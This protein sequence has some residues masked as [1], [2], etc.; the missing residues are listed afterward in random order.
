VRLCGQGNVC[1]N[2]EMVL[3]RLWI[4]GLFDGWCVR[5]GAMKCRSGAHFG[6]RKPSQIQSPPKILTGF[7]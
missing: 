4:R 1:L 6:S 5:R 7:E 2:R 3:S